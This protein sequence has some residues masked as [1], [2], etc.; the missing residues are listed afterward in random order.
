[1]VVV[2]GTAAAAAAA[3]AAAEAE[4]EAVAQ[5]QRQRHGSSSV[6]SVAGVVAV[7]M[8]LFCPKGKDV[9]YR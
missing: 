5:Q 9:A 7:R 4:A 6:V 8:P 2:S 3:A 1:M